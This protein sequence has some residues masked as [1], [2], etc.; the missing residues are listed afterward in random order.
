MSNSVDSTL[1]E[2]GTRYGDFVG[3]AEITQS[4]KQAMINSPN[5]ATI[6]ADQK[7]ALEMVAHKIGRILNGDPD[8]LDSW[9][10]IIGYTRLVEQRLIEKAIDPSG[11]EAAVYLNDTG[12]NTKIT[13]AASLAYATDGSKCG[14]ESE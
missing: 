9:H 5:W 14:V 1:E 7:E 8:Y 6:A 12:M 2:R 13:T 4:L 11:L 10:D 3:H